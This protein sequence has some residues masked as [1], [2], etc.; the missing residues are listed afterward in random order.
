M[1]FSQREEEGKGLLPFIIFLSRQK[2]R[3]SPPPCVSFTQ[4]FSQQDRR[5]RQTEELVLPLL[6]K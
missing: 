3:L 1:T 4:F 5:D 2:T 6:Q